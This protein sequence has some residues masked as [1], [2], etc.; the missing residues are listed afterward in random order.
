MKQVLLAVPTKSANCQHFNKNCGHSSTS[1]VFMADSEDVD[2]KTVYGST[3]FVEFLINN[4]LTHRQYGYKLNVICEDQ[5]NTAYVDCF[6]H[7]D[8]KLK[9]FNISYTRA[10]K[11]NL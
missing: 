3:N 9:Q 8:P 5:Q 7:L 1:K 11:N 4:L 6:L 2:Y 10:L